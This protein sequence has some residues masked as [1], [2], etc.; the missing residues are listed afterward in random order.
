[1]SI[2][3]TNSLST[4]KPTGSPSGIGELAAAQRRKTRLLERLEPVDRNQP[5]ALRRVMKLLPLGIGPVLIDGDH[6]GRP[7]DLGEHHPVFVEFL[8]EERP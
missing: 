4:A 3:S 7:V 2:G 5:R 1:L 8:V 6:L